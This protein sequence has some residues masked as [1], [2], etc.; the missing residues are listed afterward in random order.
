M[1][2]FSAMK[3]NCN[4]EKIFII[5]HTVNYDVQMISKKYI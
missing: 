3:S 1:N 5:M 4:S 2:L